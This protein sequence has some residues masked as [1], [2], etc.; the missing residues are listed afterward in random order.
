ML[1]LNLGSGHDYKIGYVN[2]DIG[3]ELHG[4]NIFCDLKHDLSKSIP[5]EDNSVD[6]CYTTHFMEHLENPFLFMEEMI[7]VTKNNGMIYAA[8]P[9]F[10]LSIGHKYFF[11]KE[12]FKI[13]YGND[14]RIVFV[15]TEYFHFQDF[16]EWDEVRVTMRIKK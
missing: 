13:F 4:K 2:I 1:K 8:V 6:E 15:S 9:I 16:H 12:W 5:Y 11:P 3:G 7:R 14:K 10:D